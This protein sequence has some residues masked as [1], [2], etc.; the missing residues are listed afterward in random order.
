[1]N[2]EVQFTPSDFYNQDAF[3]QYSDSS[4][5]FKHTGVDEYGNKVYN[6]YITTFDESNLVAEEKNLREIE[7][8]LLT[9]FKTS[10]II[11]T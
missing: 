11:N 2:R 10:D 3:K 8:M 6:I 4:Y 5:K 7:E 1:M 9:D